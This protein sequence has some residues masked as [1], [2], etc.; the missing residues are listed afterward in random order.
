MEN[1]PGYDQTQD[2]AELVRCEVTNDLVP[3]D[4][5]VVL[6]GKRVSARGKQILLE[7]L[8]TGAAIDGE[9][10]APTSLRRFGCAFLDGILIGIVGALIG[11]V[12]GAAAGV[13]GSLNAP[14]VFGSIELVSGLVAFS[15]FVI[16]HAS[17]GQTV[18]K[19]AG[20]IKVVNL[21][22]SDIT[23]GTSL[24]RGFMYNG[25]Q[26]IPSLLVVVFGEAFFGDFDTLAP[27][28]ILGIVIGIYVLA[29]CITVL[30]TQKKQAIHDFV[31]GTR[32]VMLEA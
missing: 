24:V 18:G 16:M 28:D 23:F 32:V 20:K 8:S 21:D 4:E 22:G 29:N 1:Q 15:Y 11:G 17:R 5:T 3:I 14:R 30:V 26:L 13:T 27:Y 6:H 7:R 2:A 10:E 12:I 31:A 9:L 19:I 25:I